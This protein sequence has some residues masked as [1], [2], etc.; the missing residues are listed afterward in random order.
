MNVKII[1][2]PAIVRI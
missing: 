1:P 2:E